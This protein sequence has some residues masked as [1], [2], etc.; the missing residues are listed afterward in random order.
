MGEDNWLIIRSRGYPSREVARE[1]GQLLKDALLLAGAE[2]W[3]GIDVGMDRATSSVAQFIKDGSAEDGILLR[4]DIFGLDVFEDVEA[5]VLQM[6]MELSAPASPDDLLN[7]IRDLTPLAAFMD[8]RSRVSAQLINDALFPLTPES[9]L[10]ILMTAIES[11]WERPKRSASIAALT[12][13]LL[14]HLNTMNGSA[15]DKDDVAKRVNDIRVQ[16]ISRMCKGKI[17][18]LL[19]KDRAKEFENL[20]EARSGFAHDGKGRAMLH[21]EGDVAQRLAFDVLLAELRDRKNATA[22]AG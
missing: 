15:D 13:A 17:T 4:D 10:L 9:R 21:S 2:Q 6:K 18:D 12:D 5:R 22:A 11:L 14:A 7:S 1:N 20:Y 19:G 16:S 8:S 3:A